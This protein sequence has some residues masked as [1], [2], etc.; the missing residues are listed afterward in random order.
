M[1]TIGIC[2]DLETDRMYLKKLCDRYFDEH[3]EAF[4]CKMF[5]SGEE[6]LNYKGEKLLLLFLDIEMQGTDG[7]DVMEQLVKNSKVWRIVFV[8]SHKERVFDTFGLK[9]LDFGV[10]P[11][12]YQRISHWIDIA[13]NEE[14][15]NKVIQFKNDS[16]DSCVLIEDIIMLIGEGNYIRLVLKEESRI[17]V[18]TIKQ[19]EK[20]LEGTCMLRVHKSYIVNMNYISKIEKQQVYMY[21]KTI[22]PVG[23]KYNESTKEKVNKFIMDKIRERV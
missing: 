23:R 21:D 10:K 16:E 22:V 3:G 12:E 13:K 6:V 4:S 18:G 9:T 14:R 19:W 1:I 20:K 5:S 11:V 2:D 7:I 15:R 8:S 17:Y